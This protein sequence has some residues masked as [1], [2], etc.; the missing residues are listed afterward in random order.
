MPRPKKRSGVNVEGVVRLFQADGSAA[1]DVLAARSLVT[2][3]KPTGGQEE[4]EVDYCFGGDAT[5]RDVYLRTVYPLL[6]K[7]VAGY[8]GT[9]LVLGATGAGKTHT[10]QGQARDGK[11]GLASLAVEGLFEALHAK[12]AQLGQRAAKERRGG[13]RGLSFQVEST[14][15][16]LHNE[17]L[18]D[19][20]AKGGGKGGAAAAGLSVQEDRELGWHV[21]G[22]TVRSASDATAL[23]DHYVQGVANRDKKS[24]DVGTVH[25]RA[26]ALFS[27]RVTQFQPAVGPE[28]LDQH[29][30]STLLLVDMPGGERLGVDPEI[31]RLR[32]GVRLNKSLLAYGSLVRQLAQPGGREYIEYG[33]S[34]LTQLLV[35]AL[36]GDSYTTALAC[37]KAGSFEE[38]AQT[39][40][41]V[42]LMRRVQNFPCVEHERHRQLH[43]RQRMRLQHLQ[44]Q[45]AQL[46]DQIKALPADG[47]DPADLAMQMARVHELDLRIVQE[48]EEKAELAEEKEALLHRLNK[49]HEAD[50]ALLQEKEQLQTALIKS[51]EERLEIARA[52]IDLQVENNAVQSEMENAKFTF[53]QRILELEGQLLSGEVKEETLAQLR[54]EL[55]LQVSELKGE[56]SRLQ[57]EV[58]KAKDDIEAL[59]REKEQRLAKERA[60]HELAMTKARGELEREAAE[61]KNELQAQL[62]ADYEDRIEKLRADKEEAVGKLQDERTAL[63]QEL[64]AVKAEKEKEKVDAQ[65]TLDRETT[66][67]K[68]EH[69]KEM[70]E[71]KAKNDAERAQSKSEHD[72]QLSQQRQQAE[73]ELSQKTGELEK[74]LKQTRTQLEDERDQIKH[75]LETERDNLKRELEEKLA[76]LESKL[77]R[78]T[79]ELEQAQA[80]LE[81]RS[82]ELE[83]LRERLEA[84]EADLQLARNEAAESAAANNRLQKELEEA[85]LEVARN[86][87]LREENKVAVRRAEEAESAA[88]AARK[89]ADRAISGSTVAAAQL[90]D[91]RDGFERKLESHLLEVGDLAKAVSIVKADPKSGVLPS[92][93]LPA[94]AERLARD[95]HANATARERQHRSEMD[96]QQQ[97]LQDAQRKLRAL[98]LGYRQLRYRLEDTRSGGLATIGGGGISQRGNTPEVIHEDRLCGEV[99]AAADTADPHTLV[100]ELRMRCH[101]LEQELQVTRLRESALEQNGGS[102]ADVL[103]VEG[104]VK[105]RA[106]NKLLKERLEELR[107][108]RERTPNTELRH[109]NEKLRNRL[110]ELEQVDKSRV[111]M[112]YEIAELKEKLRE[113]AKQRDD[114]SSMGELRTQMK[115]FQH[116]VQMDLEKEVSSLT[117]RS[118]MAEEQLVQLQAYMAQS[119]LQ[120]QKEIMRLRSIV[121]RYEPNSLNGG[122]GGSGAFPGPP[123]SAGARPPAAG[124]GSPGATPAAAART[125]RSS[126]SSPANPNPPLF[127]S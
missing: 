86:S 52:L 117:A 90:S 75:D 83:R 99:E 53:E 68:A 12:G 65:A 87:T 36:G 35:E 47:N 124:A 70:A 63:D 17:E 42:A 62:M 110:L 106:E 95:L 76:D 18:R 11:G 3:I 10:L 38:T 67:L 54:G 74:E 123:P 81:E 79:A 88:M 40:Q 30:V 21:Q 103:H 46:N 60:D 105:L 59:E 89:E 14:F 122:G 9:V 25:E 49:M 101:E 43:E 15:V 91:A 66:T 100:A 45:R 107:L 125:S 85:Q 57:G 118:T 22:A 50:D 71:L 28:E 58:E 51:E 104:E 64:H 82:A 23:L 114:A 4:Y 77:R 1:R 93:K 55:E 92:D 127:A 126:G 98:Y 5:E 115:T 41:H 33:E 6:R 94:A 48:V 8:N 16:E 116:E 120:Y 69:E 109:Q 34:L 108:A 78:V 102:R 121:S 113:T 119:T 44:E 72:S 73:Q 97:R 112:G 2:H 20:Y 26:A 84:T 31:L 32:E 13:G 56:R 39:L 111:Q 7:V 24:M 19:L 96:E 61:G 37:I 27:V 80:D 29:I